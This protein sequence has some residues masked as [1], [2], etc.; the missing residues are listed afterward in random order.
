MKNVPKYSITP[1][2]YKYLDSRL[3][4]LEPFKE[5]KLQEIGRDVYNRL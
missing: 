2:G 1:Q 3:I 5:D 4:H